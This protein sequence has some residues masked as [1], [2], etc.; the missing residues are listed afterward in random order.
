MSTV[1]QKDV[2]DSKEDLMVTVFRCQ[3]SPHEIIGKKLSSRN[4]DLV[5]EWTWEEVR[6]RQNSEEEN[7]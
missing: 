1:R 6:S 4:G 2:N 3:A 5:K 7:C